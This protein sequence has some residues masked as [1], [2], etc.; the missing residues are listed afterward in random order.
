LPSDEEALASSRRSR[1]GLVLFL[2]YLILYG[3]FVGAAVFAPGLMGSTLH[4]VN[5]A[6]LYGFA[7]IGSALGL[8][9]LYMGLSRG[10]R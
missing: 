5:L 10:G 1:R 6:V 3:G 2:V 9:L 4:G 7:L 8:A